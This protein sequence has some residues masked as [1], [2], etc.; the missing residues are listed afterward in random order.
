[1]Q[2]YPDVAV[3]QAR[4]AGGQAYQ[5]R[6][7]STDEPPVKGEC[8]PTRTRRKSRTDDEVEAVLR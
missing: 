5:N 4:Q 7:E 6:A 3:V 2:R 1:M 8:G